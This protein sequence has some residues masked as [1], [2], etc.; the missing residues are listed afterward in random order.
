MP[1]W[2][3]LTTCCDLARNDCWYCAARPGSTSVPA[4][5]RVR[6]VAHRASQGQGLDG[7]EGVLLGHVQ[8]P[9][10]GVEPGQ[11]HGHE[12]DREYC[13]RGEC[14]VHQPPESRGEVEL[15]RHQGRGKQYPQDDCPCGPGLRGRLASL[16]GGVQFGRADRAEGS[17]RRQDAGLHEASSLLVVGDRGGGRATRRAVRLLAREQG[18]GG[19]RLVLA[20]PVEDQGEFVLRARVVGLGRRRLLKIGVGGGAV[21]RVGRQVLRPAGRKGSVAADQ[22]DVRHLRVHVVEGEVQAGRRPGFRRV[23]LPDGLKLSA[24]L[25]E[26]DGG[27]PGQAAGEHHG[28]RRSRPDPDRSGPSP[29]PVSRGRCE[30]EFTAI[31]PAHCEPS[32]NDL[33]KAFA[34]RRF[35]PNRFELLGRQAPD[36]LSVLG[37]R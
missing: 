25:G 10:F 26:Q 6:V 1:T 23:P 37:A 15:E 19:Q 7:V 32:H 27:Q 18:V 14:G 11:R 13:R 9:G 20:D 29:V 3:T 31:T 21:A 22:Q 33:T 17:D 34:G 4:L 36:R 2:P 28:G 35:G 30:E 24:Q 12:G 5:V 8:P 16:V